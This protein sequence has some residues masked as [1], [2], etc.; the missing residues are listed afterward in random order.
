MNSLTIIKINN[1]LLRLNNTWYQLVISPL[2]V[3]AI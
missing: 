3:K 2:H 1:F